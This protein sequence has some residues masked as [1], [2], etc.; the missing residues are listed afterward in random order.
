MCSFTILS[1]ICRIAFKHI[2]TH[3]ADTACIVAPLET[4]VSLTAPEEADFTA[5][6]ESSILRMDSTHEGTDK[7]TAGEGSDI[8]SVAFDSLQQVSPILPATSAPDVFENSVTS[9]VL[10]QGF[11]SSTP[12]ST[13]V[14]SSSSS[15]SNYHSAA[16]SRITV[17]QSLYKDVLKLQS[18]HQQQQELLERS[19][20]FASPV[21][22]RRNS[23]N[24]NHER[25]PLSDLDVNTKRLNFSSHDFSDE[26]S[27]NP[28]DYVSKTNLL[29]KT[30][31]G[32]LATTSSVPKLGK[33]ENKSDGIFP[34]TTN[35]TDLNDKSS[36]FSKVTITVLLCG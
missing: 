36:G 32:V 27:Y 15:V 20:S 24:R 28:D 23:L 3:L 25:I 19:Y 2:H 18:Y 31:N 1:F 13:I 4:A 5:D 11:G 29:E 7:F 34:E 21:A 8:C 33:S 12:V 6:E 35:R 16:A 17:G 9:P 30:D 26:R 14:T 22:Q 10:A